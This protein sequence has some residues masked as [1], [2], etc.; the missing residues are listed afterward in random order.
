MRCKPTRL[1]LVKKES[2][3]FMCLL[4]TVFA[5]PS[6]TGPM[7]NLLDLRWHGEKI[8]EFMVDL[9]VRLSD[10]QI[11]VPDSQFLASVGGKGFRPKFGFKIGLGSA[12]HNI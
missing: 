8:A 12:S 10:S 2:P 6:A 4:S 11:L 5:I 1:P 7:Q 3:R 9:V